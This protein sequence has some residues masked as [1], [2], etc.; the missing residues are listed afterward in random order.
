M[1]PLYKNFILD[2]YKN[3]RQV[4]QNTSQLIMY[5][6][7]GVS[8]QGYCL[9]TILFTLLSAVYSYDLK[10]FE[11]LYNMFLYSLMLSIPFIYF[12][13][14]LYQNKELIDLTSV[15]VQFMFIAVSIVLSILTETIMNNV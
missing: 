3:S 9:V 7:S 2:K 1:V 11:R 12:W 4:D 6:G 15:K 5:G 14:T 13:L 8:Y 10:L